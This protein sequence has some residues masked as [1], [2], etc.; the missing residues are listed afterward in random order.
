[1]SDRNSR[2]PWRFVDLHNHVVPGVDDGAAT[3]EIGVQ[4]VRQASELGVEA[5]WATPHLLP[6]RHTAD[7]WAKVEAGFASLTAAVRAAAIPVEMQLA[8]EFYLDPKLPEFIDRHGVG[9][10]RGGYV[11]LEMPS[12]EVPA[13]LPQVVFELKLRGLRPI[14]AHPERNAQAMTRLPILRDAI[15]VGALM[16]L[17]AESLIDERYPPMKAAAERLLKAGLIHLAASDAHHP[18]RRPFTVLPL[19][20]ERVVELIGSAAADRLFDHVP[21]ALF[22]GEAVEPEAPEM[23][24]SSRLSLWQQ[25]R[26]SVS[27]WL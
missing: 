27:S 19:A 24:M 11:L 1:M 9:V 17:D 4:L 22:A 21:R 13:Y 20:R 7:G 6:E 5:L 18:E 8:A 15:R 2:A 16:Q 3:V 23:E 26:R 25:V 10:P 12:V 14:I